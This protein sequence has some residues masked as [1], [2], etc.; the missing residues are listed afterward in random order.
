VTYG[1][2]PLS[3][4]TV[5]FFPTDSTPG[6]GASAITDNSGKYVLQSR[7]VDG[8]TKPG[9]IPGKYRVTVSR[10]VKSDG[11][12]A[13]P[14]PNKGPMTEGAREELPPEYSFK[15][16]LTAD[17]SKDKGVIDFKLEKKN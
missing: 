7:S 17:V 8:K 14:D 6:Q 3:Q 9:A 11:S 13:K 5:I 1:D 10:M 15:S 16:E 2:Q 4:A 12:V